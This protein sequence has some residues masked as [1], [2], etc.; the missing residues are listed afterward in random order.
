MVTLGKSILHNVGVVLVALA[1]A[2]IGTRIDRLFGVPE[3]RTPA[4]DAIG[5]VILGAGF[6]LR[7]W[8]ALRFYEHG[9]KVIAL[10]PQ[11]T[12]LTS[13]PY[14]FSRNPLY[15]GG[16]VFVFLG[17]ALI[18]GSPAALLFTV[19]HLPLVDLFIRRE[20]GQLEQWF[21]EEWRRYRKR[22]NRWLQLWPG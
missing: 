3:F 1:L 4:I 9:M 12:L 10:A 11:P 17:A 7:V 16:N 14:R 6:L 5:G 15:L 8:A 19:A 22:V 21:G 18:L 2:F 13:G 20:E